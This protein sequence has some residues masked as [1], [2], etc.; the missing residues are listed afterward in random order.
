MKMDTRQTHEQQVT[1]LEEVLGELRQGPNSTRRPLIWLAGDS[2][3]DNKF[4]IPND[5]A[6]AL[7][8]YQV[9][10]SLPGMGKSAWL[11]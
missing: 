6:P 1:H 10:L 3:L 4:W 11:C 7:D 5:T 2:S 9:L 8:G